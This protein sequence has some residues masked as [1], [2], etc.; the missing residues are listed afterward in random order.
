MESDLI[1]P[2]SSVVPV[3]VSDPGA[4]LPTTW[5]WAPAPTVKPAIVWASAMT[6]GTEELSTIL[7]VGA[8][9]PGF[10]SGGEVKGCGPLPAGGLHASIGG[11]AG[12]GVTTCGVC[13]AG[14]GLVVGW[15]WMTVAVIVT[16]C[17]PLFRL[18]C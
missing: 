1:V 7:S 15:F 9:G 11:P 5:T 8:G 17:E 4:L 6:I 16:G 18:I 14:G 10:Q 2:L 3:T 13:A 12:G